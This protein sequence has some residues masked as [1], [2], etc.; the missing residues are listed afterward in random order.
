MQG[1]EV[2]EGI[3]RDMHKMCRT[4]LSAVIGEGEGYEAYLLA[5]FGGTWECVELAQNMTE[6]SHESGEG[7]EA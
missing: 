6:I 5:A 2:T 4:R 1:Q 3:R 7:C